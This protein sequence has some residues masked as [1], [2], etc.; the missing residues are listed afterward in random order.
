MPRDWV[1]ALRL[2]MKGSTVYIEERME[3]GSAG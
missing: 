3:V 1:F 2:H